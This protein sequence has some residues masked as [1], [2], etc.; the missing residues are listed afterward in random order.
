[1]SQPPQTPAAA[2]KRAIEDAITPSPSP[3]LRQ[4]AKKKNSRNIPKG[5]AHGKPKQATVGVL[6]PIIYRP[7]GISASPTSTSPQ[8]VAPSASSDLLAD[9][10][11]ATV[12]DAQDTEDSANEFEPAVSLGESDVE[13]IATRVKQAT[14]ALGNA[15]FNSIAAFLDAICTTNF[16]AR[17]DCAEI[18]KEA[19]EDGIPR[20]LTLLSQ[21]V[22]ATK[23]LRINWSH[24]EMQSLRQRK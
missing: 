16:P 13:L 12:E 5:G 20:M 1:M 9:Y 4:P 8:I 23:R 15:G 10:S 19:W 11:Q 6:E 2:A 24:I 21:H 18:Q 17:S 3:S 14:T 22:A 7:H